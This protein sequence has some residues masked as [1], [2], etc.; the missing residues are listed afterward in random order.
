MVSLTLDLSILPVFLLLVCR[1]A[2]IV[3]AAPLLGSGR[4]PARLKAALALTVSLL[5]TPVAG[6]VP[7]AASA[8]S[9]A[10]AAGGEFLLG[11]AIG[12]SASL[13]FSAVQ[14]AGELADSQSAFGFAGMVSPQTGE[15]NSVI[16]ELQMSLAWLIFLA[17]NGHHVV[18][19]G[20]G[21]SLAAAPLGTGP[22]LSAPVLTDAL[23]GLMLASIRIAAPVVAAALLADLALG[24]LTRAAPQMNLFAVGFP[25]K[26]AVG[27]LAAMLSLPAFSAIFRGLIPATGDIITGI[28]AAAR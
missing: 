15:R 14:M 18:L 16:G 22:G 11:L 3:V 21:K 26:L 25:I 6:A 28:L 13:I 7:E 23:V 1:V 17:A 12:F 5:L 24:L 10:L 19:E 27:L 8:L 2:G 4:V 9:M 20:I